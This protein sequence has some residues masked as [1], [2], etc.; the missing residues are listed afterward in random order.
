MSSQ[1]NE[2]EDWVDAAAGLCTW[3]EMSYDGRAEWACP[4]KASTISKLCTRHHDLREYRLLNHEPSEP[5]PGAGCIVGQHLGW[6]CDLAIVH[7]FGNNLCRR[8]YRVWWLG[9]PG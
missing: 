1:A 5:T 7:V 8:H 3:V 6:H 2:L 4:H 9:Y